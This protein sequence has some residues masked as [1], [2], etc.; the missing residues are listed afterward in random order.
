M[1]VPIE[2]KNIDKFDPLQV[3]TINQLCNEFD[4]QSDRKKGK[5]Q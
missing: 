4:T 5:H 3:P 1:C 2:V